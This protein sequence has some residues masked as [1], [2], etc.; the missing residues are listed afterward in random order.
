MIAWLI[1][2]CATN[3]ALTLVAVLVAAGF[4]VRAFRATPLDA[5]PDLS[6]TQVIVSAEWMGRS[7]D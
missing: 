6:D 2:W 3:R 1:R 4:G 5:I 7:P